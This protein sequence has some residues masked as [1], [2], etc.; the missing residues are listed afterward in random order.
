M[1]TEP[2]KVLRF[3]PRQ[4]VG[5]GRGPNEALEEGTIAMGINDVGAIVLKTKPVRWFDQKKP[6]SKASPVF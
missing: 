4:G 5:G 1:A 3:S 6:E 2:K